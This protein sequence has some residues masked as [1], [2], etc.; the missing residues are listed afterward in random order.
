MPIALVLRWV[1]MRWI[2]QH[3]RSWLSSSK[4]RRFGGQLAELVAVGAIFFWEE[5]SFEVE[6]HMQ[7]IGWF[8]FWGGFEEYFFGMN[9]ETYS[10]FEWLHMLSM[11]LLHVSFKDQHILQPSYLWKRGLFDIVQFRSHSPTVGIWMI[12]LKTD[13][14]SQTLTLVSFSKESLTLL[15]PLPNTTGTSLDCL[16][17]LLLGF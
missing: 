14:Q 5:V 9:N 2:P 6:K 15:K 16:H 1:S 13:I 7:G 8:F 17:S 12:N 3:V 11:R 4:R 10:T